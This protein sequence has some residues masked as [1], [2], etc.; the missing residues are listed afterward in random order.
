M[1]KSILHFQFKTTRSQELRAILEQRK[2]K[3]DGSS[4][5]SASMTSQDFQEEADDVYSRSFNVGSKLE[6]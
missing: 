6:Y 3:T 4:S 1:L 5:L 2:N